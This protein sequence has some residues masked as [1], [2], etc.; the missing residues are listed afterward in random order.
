MR[1]PTAILIV[2]IVIA[3]AYLLAN[4]RQSAVEAI[5]GVL[6]VQTT[7]TL[8]SQTTTTYPN[9]V[10]VKLNAC[11]GMENQAL[12]DNCY[13]DLARSFDKMKRSMDWAA[14][15]ERIN[16]EDLRLNCEAVLTESS[17]LCDK[18][19]NKLRSERCLAE[20]KAHEVGCSTPLTPEMEKELQKGRRY[21]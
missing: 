14:I 19:S 5:S 11:R 17:H 8:P 20:V 21:D 10:T 16:D 4:N 18:I 1:L 6:T 13:D 12:R 15:C 2:F 7:T 9:S 3:G